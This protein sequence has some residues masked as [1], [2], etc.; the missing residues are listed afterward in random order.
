V[1]PAAVSAKVDSQYFVITRN[2]PCWEAIM[3]QRNVGVYVPGE[4]PSPDLE[5]IVLLES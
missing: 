3:Q 5:L 2:G 1:P 4:L